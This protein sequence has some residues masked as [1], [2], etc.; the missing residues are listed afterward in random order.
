VKPRFMQIATKIAQKSTSRF[1]VGCIITKGGNVLSVGWNDMNRTHP[2]CKSHGNYL[3]AEVRA[4]IALSRKDLTNATAYVSRITKNN[5]FGNSRPCPICLEALRLAKI[6][7]IC[8]TTNEG[9]KEE[10]I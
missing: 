5:S 9:Y 4:L 3:H 7:S 2:K 6:K 8:Y 10:R 1:R